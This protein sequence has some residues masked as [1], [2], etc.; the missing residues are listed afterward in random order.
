MLQESSG[1]NKSSLLLPQVQVHRL[2][3]VKSMP[4]LGNKHLRHQLPYSND[5]KIIYLVPTDCTRDL[6]R[7]FERDRLEAYNSP[8]TIFGAALAA[9]NHLKDS[10][11]VQRLQANVCVT[12]ALIEESGP[13]Y[14]RST[15]S[16]YSSS[17][18]ERPHQRRRS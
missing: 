9:L 11:M 4:T 5:A 12:A 13:G 15:T 14:S 16:S 8:Q 7:N 1:D 6:L 18:S 10:P 2:T 17:R 3:S